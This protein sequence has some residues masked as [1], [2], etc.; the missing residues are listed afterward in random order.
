MN[1]HAL[2]LPVLCRGESSQPL[3]R[4]QTLEKSLIY[5]ISAATKARPS[6]I[7]QHTLQYIT[8][9]YIQGVS[10]RA[11]EWVLQR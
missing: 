8:Y 4:R 3:D 10:K 9:G 7:H 6:I 5:A 1:P 11:R 2:L